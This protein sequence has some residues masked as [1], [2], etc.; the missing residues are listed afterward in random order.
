MIDTAEL[1]RD[2]EQQFERQTKAFQNAV[3]RFRSIKDDM[4]RAVACE[5]IYA[6]DEACTPKVFA[7]TPNNF[8]TSQRA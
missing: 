1:L 2:F 4:P 7:T 5:V 6:I 3:E 8:V